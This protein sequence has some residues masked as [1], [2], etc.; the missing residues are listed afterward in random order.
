MPD[1]RRPNHPRGNREH[2]GNRDSHDNRD[3][4]GNRD[5]DRNRQSRENEP[6][7]T[8]RTVA[9]VWNAEAGDYLANGY[10]DA[11][12]NLRVELV[13]RATV[14]P[15]VKAMATAAD[16]PLT[17]T[18]LRRFFQHCRA[19]EAAL[20]SKDKT[21][22]QAQP[23]VKK[24]DYV[25]SDST[26][27]GK[28]QKIPRIFADFIEINVKKIQSENDFLNGFM[29]HFEALVGFGGLHVRDEKRS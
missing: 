29:P 20:K 15:L 19:I 14:E 5:R 13:E 1:D 28:D 9:E 21:W 12:G 16:K 26:K 2:R 3:R 25:A 7:S 27:L 22:G 23:D 10:F 17:R 24:L 6:G 11:D 8:A 18:Q 4:H